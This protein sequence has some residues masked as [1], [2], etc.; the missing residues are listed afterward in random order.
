MKDFHFHEDSD[1]TL[2]TCGHS[3][4]DLILVYINGT[5]IV[6]KFGFLFFIIKLILVYKS[7]EGY[8]WSCTALHKFTVRGGVTKQNSFCPRDRR[9][10]LNTVV[11]ALSREEA[12]QCGNFAVVFS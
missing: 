9:E 11:R 4:L 3:G 10:R 2:S 7:D 6:C 1:S 12:Y 8:V 5:D